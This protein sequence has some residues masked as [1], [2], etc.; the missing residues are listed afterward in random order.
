[1]KLSTGTILDLRV[2]ERALVGMMFAYNFALLVTLYLLKPARDSL[3]LDELG[4]ERLP[5]VF[6]AVAAAV[7]PVTLLYGR[8]GRRTRLSALVNATTLALIGSLVAMRFALELDAG[9]VFFL[10]Y[11]WVSIYSV[12]AT[13]QYWLLA[14]AVFDPSQAKRVFALLSFGAIL[15]AIV[16]GELTG[17]LVDGMGVRTR[18]LLW[19]AAGVLGGTVVLL[20][21]IRMR[22]SGHAS[23][24][25]ADAPNTDE[26]ALQVLR[27]SRHLQLI[28]AV[29]AVAV[30]TTALVDFQFK[31]VSS[32]AFPVRSDLTTFMG[33]FYGRVSIVA[34]ALQFFVAPRIIRVRGVGGALLL[35]PVALTVGSVA[36]LAVPGLIAGT[37][38]RGAD[39]SL[40]HSIDRTGRELLFLPVP[41]AAKKQVKVFID[42]FVDQ[43][44]QGLAGLVLLG[45]LAVGLTVQSLSVVVIALLALWIGLAV[46]ARRSYIQAFRETLPRKDGEPAEAE[47]QDAPAGLPDP[48]PNVPRL[49]AQLDA[50]R[51]RTVLDAL[52]TLDA[53][54]V[55]LP[56]EQAHDLLQHRSARVRRR[57]IA[58]L[59]KQREEGFADVVADFLRDRDAEVRLEA[60]R[61]LYRTL[62]DRRRPLLKAGL[63]H[64]DLRIRAAAVGVVAESGT[65]DE[66]ALITD[67][68]LRSLL[69]HT[70]AAEVETS[71]E[72]L[73]ALGVLDRPDFHDTI[74]ALLDNPSPQV[75]RAAIQAAGQTGD[76]LFVGKLLR[77]LAEKPYEKAA[78]EALV[79]YGDRIFGTLYDHLT[80]DTVA[81]PIRRNIPR[82]LAELPTQ[83]AVD[84]LL[85]SLERLRAPLLYDVAKALNKIRASNPG[86]RFNQE[87]IDVAV[88]GEI[89]A[90]ATVQA[91]LFHHGRSPDPYARAPDATDVHDALIRE[92]KQSLERV[93]RMLGLRYPSADMHSAYLGL[94]E[95]DDLRASAAEFLDSVLDWDFKRFLVPLLDEA[96]DM[97]DV[98]VAEGMAGQPFPTW[99]AALRD[100]LLHRHP[101]PLACALAAAAENTPPPLPE[102]IADIARSACTPDPSDDPPEM[103]GETPPPFRPSASGDGAAGSRETDAMG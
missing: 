85:L 22:A 92:R 15:G 59:A 23:A 30:L 80:D 68:V 52:D 84:L 58:L 35:L 93:F 34:L 94:T 81:E 9:W 26:P 7:V 67:Y 16:G 6:L 60:A 88:R 63:G 50:P 39:Q 44:M 53:S 19:V 102:D 83:P 90:L 87:A 97:G 11:V 8:L 56:V 77:L 75:V 40:K 20:N 65:D 74:R 17:F 57:T 25:A 69:D 73:K 42:V 86:L 47:R 48:P 96:P 79:A 46:W 91:A 3:F 51:T 55:E 10:L 2:G 76:R 29:I 38:L 62:D 33:R 101:R 61:F 45:A 14:G 66:R 43:G 13:S 54:D 41:L 28:T 70:G 1:M 21:L 89:R 5:F 98:R 71:V 82:M 103:H 18:D 99:Q 37:A 24:A 32:A 27:S 31:T 64:D 12:L 36:M 95:S 100:L 78:R 49:L 4:P 72:A